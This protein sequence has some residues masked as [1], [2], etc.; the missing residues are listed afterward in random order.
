MGNSLWMTTA[1]NGTFEPFVQLPGAGLTGLAAVSTDAGRVDVFVVGLDKALWH[2]STQVDTAGRPT[3]WAAWESLGGTLTSA[4][5]AAS[6]E[7]G[8]LMVAGRNSLGGISYR[9]LSGSTW[10][11]WQAAGGGSVTAPALEV[12]DGSTYRVRVVGLDGIVWVRPIPS[13]GADPGS[14]WASSG[15]ASTFSP[16]VSGTMWWAR[17]VRAE[18][19]PNGRSGVLQIRDATGLSVDLG[20]G[21]NSAVAL[22]ELADGGFWTFGRGTDGALWV[23]KSDSTGANTWERVGGYLV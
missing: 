2:T 9:L 3:T 4:P 21:I 16:V 22:V 8:K 23:N 17:D 11:P 18:A 6:N 12:Y 14:A 20:G 15:L 5:S 10:G 13:S 19:W 1:V 7:W